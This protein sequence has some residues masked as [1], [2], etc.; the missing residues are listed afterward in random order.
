[1]ET[2]TRSE[3]S[4]QIPQGRKIQNGDTR[5]DSNLP[6]DRGVGHIHR[7]Q[8]CLLPYT[9]TKP[10]Q[11]ISEVSC[12]V[13]NI[14]IQST[15]LW[16]VRSSIGVHCCGQRGQ[17]DCFTKGYKNPPV[18]RLVG[19]GQIPPNLST[20]YTNTSSSVSGPRLASKL[21]KIRTGPKTGL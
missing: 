5:N 21:G 12:I 8:G 6:T 20:A 16:S 18:P 2:Y 4:Q 15:T 13:Q 1:M 7:L 14:P 11:K 9:N 3:Q 10:I 19:P 17:S